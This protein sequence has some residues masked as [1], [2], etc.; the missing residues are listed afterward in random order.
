MERLASSLPAGLSRLRASRGARVVLSVGALLIVVLG[1][2][3]LA[4][5]RLRVRLLG[6]TVPAASLE[7][8]DLVRRMTGRPEPA[9][10]ATRR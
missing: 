2:T 3:L 9:L 7:A 10:I 5:P 6:G 8:R 4:S 1:L